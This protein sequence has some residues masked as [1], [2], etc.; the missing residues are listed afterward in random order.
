VDEDEALANA[1]SK[2]VAQVN[3]TRS[4]CISAPDRP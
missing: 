3:G 1:L 2:A 4:S